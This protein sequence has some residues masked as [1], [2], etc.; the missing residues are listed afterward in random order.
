MAARRA[1]AAPRR[2]GTPRRPG[3]LRRPIGERPPAVERRTRLWHYEIDTLMARGSTACVRSLVEHES[4]YTALGTLTDRTA[5]TSTAR[6]IALIP[7]QPRVVRTITA[8]NGVEP[9]EW[10]EIEERAGAALHFANPYHA[11]ERGTNENTNGL[12]REVQLKRTNLARLTQRDC[13]RIA[14]QLKQRPRKR[15]GFRTQRS[16]MNPNQNCCTSHLN[17]QFSPTL[18]PHMSGW[19]RAVLWKGMADSG[20]A[21]GIFTAAPQP[22]QGFS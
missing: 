14:R 15:L 12:I 8:D 3:H 9:T 19:P 21:H 17:S 6:A 7:R 13:N 2:R 22:Y 10:G 11:W 1:K 18:A 20:D 4:G 5:A 16:V